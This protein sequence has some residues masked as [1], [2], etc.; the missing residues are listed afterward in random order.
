M[1]RYLAFFLL[2]FI[3]NAH[4]QTRI[5]AVIAV[6]EGH[7]IT[8]IELENEFRV[9]AVMGIP[10]P[11]EPTVF[12]KRAGLDILIARKFAFLEAVRIGV[13]KQDDSGAG[14]LGTMSTPYGNYSEQVA[15][16]MAAISAKFSSRAA[17]YRVL[18][19]NGLEIVAVEA[20]VYARLIDDAFFRRK[21]VGTVNTAEIEEFALGYF[22][23]HP[24]EFKDADGNRKEYADV[25]EELLARF[26]Q[27][28]AKDNFG[29][30]LAKQKDEGN[31]HI[32]DAELAGANLNAPSDD[33][34]DD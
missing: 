20:W 3:G 21:F 10:Y 16:Q 2:L 13:V 33:E 4:A 1:R 24:D 6:V 22:E 11:P 30:W 12:D 34:D 28:K 17:F 26:R 25:E 31:W 18:Q 9:A 27:Q 29:A 19:E 7:A 14:K 8:Q 5:D 32:L 23:K 15:A